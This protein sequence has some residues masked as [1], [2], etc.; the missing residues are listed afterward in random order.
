M[1]DDV[2]DDDLLVEAAPL[3]SVPTTLQVNRNFNKVCACNRT[4]MIPASIICKVVVGYKRVYT[5]MMANV[6]DDSPMH[7][8]LPLGSVNRWV[9]DPAKAEPNNSGQMGHDDDDD[10]DDNLE[11]LDEDSDD[12]PPPPP[13]C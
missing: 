3:R 4:G 1:F 10:N 9:I 7:P 8:T 6:T 11:N 5:A 12:T 13:Y 2:D